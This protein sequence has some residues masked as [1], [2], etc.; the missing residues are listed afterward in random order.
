MIQ[1]LALALSLQTAIAQGVPR[2]PSVRR[3][4]AAVLGA[5]AARTAARAGSAPD[6]Y[7]SYAVVPQSAGKTTLAQRSTVIGVSKSFAFPG[8]TLAQMQ[9]AGASESAAVASL[10]HARRTAALTIVTDYLDALVAQKQAAISGEAVQA[11]LKTLQAAQLRY[12]AGSGPEIDIERAQAAY[13]TAQAAQAQA[14]G[15]REGAFAALDLAVGIDPLAHPALVQPELPSSKPL[16]PAAV[17]RIALAGRADLR[18]ADEEVRSAEASLRAAGLSYAPSFDVSAGHQSGID[19]GAPISGDTVNLTVR[20]PLDTSG[21]LHAKVESAKAAL[22]TARATRDSAV[23]SVTLDAETAVAGIRA[24]QLRLVAEERAAQAAQ[25][26]ATAAS[27]GFEHGATS[28]VDVL[29]AQSQAA[30]AQS[31]L[32]AAQADAVKAHYAL[33]LAEGVNPDVAP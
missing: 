21:A 23:R 29:L 10:L 1:Q 18:A 9:A 25:A 30:T 24:S 3:A 32:V 4:E 33:E 2:D 20:L 28:A 5:Q 16:D 31:N 26:A 22:E 12:E 8:L 27:I 11:G 15:K 13:A 14:G 19:S 17:V 6:L 7:G